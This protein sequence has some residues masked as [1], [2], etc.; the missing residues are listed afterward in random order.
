[1]PNKKISIVIP[2]FNAELYIT[3][4]IQSIVNQSYKNWELLLI[5]DCSNDNSSHVIKKLMSKDNRIKYYKL[6]TNSGPAIARNKGI[7][8]ANGDFICFLDADDYWQK[9]K[10]E[11]Q[12][13]FMVKKDIEFSYH[14]YAF[15]DNDG[16]PVGKNV[17]AKK[18]LSYNEFLKNN[19]ISTITVMF[20][21]SKID[22]DLIF[23]PN[24]RYVE[25][26]ACWLN[27]LRHGYIAYGISD[28]Y[29]FYRKVPN[30]D[31]S[32]KIATQKQLWYLYRK[33]EKM[34]VLK[35][36][37]YLF[38]KNINTIIRRL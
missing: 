17:I 23:M 31:S 1:M 20:D 25:D 6:E 7:E 10:L 15:C 19:I 14:S 26:M 36:A 9:D 27:V 33:Y 2:V 13:T 24:I 28:I 5:D 18:K 8:L 22:K 12:L 38:I 35:A 21:L 29:S 30:S 32:H 3:N 11:K 37:Y 4:T 16:F 34:S